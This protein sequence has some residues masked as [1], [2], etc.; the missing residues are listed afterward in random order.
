[1]QRGQLAVLIIWLDKRQYPVLATC[2]EAISSHNK[3]E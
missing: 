3:G 2:F 1:M